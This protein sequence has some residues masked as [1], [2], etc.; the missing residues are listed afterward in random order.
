MF[1]YN[2]QAT[3]S[4]KFIDSLEKN[5]YKLYRFEMTISEE[6]HSLSINA[7]IHFF[8]WYRMF[9]L[10]FPDFELLGYSTPNKSG[11]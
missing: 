1:I 11:K 2:A 9:T 5:I 8:R 10:H 6:L 7:T 4:N 3:G